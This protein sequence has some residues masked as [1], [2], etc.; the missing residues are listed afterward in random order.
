MTSMDKVRHFQR[1]ELAEALIL[2]PSHFD[3]SAPRHRFPSLASSKFAVKSILTAPICGC[4]LPLLG[5]MA[6]IRPSVPVSHLTG[7]SGF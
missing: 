4:V 6:G 2:S 1:F 7:A 3:L 5:W